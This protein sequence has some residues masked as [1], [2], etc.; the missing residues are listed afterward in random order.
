MAS[1]V[2]WLGPVAMVIS[3]V[4]KQR[5][6]DGRFGGNNGV[7]NMDRLGLM[8]FFLKFLE[9]NLFSYEVVKW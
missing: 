5:G 7:P 4:Q 1:L 9:V 8:M 6:M 3:S 2:G